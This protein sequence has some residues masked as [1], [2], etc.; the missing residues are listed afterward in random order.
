MNKQFMRS[1]FLTCPVGVF[2]IFQ[3]EIRSFSCL[4]LVYMNLHSKRVEWVCE[5]F[6]TTMQTTRAGARQCEKIPI[7]AMIFS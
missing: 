3:A 1:L 4:R 6:Y 7:N 5:D 2:K